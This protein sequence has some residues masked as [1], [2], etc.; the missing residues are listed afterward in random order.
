MKFATLLFVCAAV[1]MAE[2]LSTE[3]FSSSL[4]TW[5]IDAF[6]DENVGLTIAT[7]AWAAGRETV[8]SVSVLNKKLPLGVF[9]FGSSRRH[10]AGHLQWDA[11]EGVVYHPGALESLCSYP[12]DAYTSGRQNIGHAANSSLVQQCGVAIEHQGTGPEFQCNYTAEDYAAKFYNYPLLQNL[13]FGKIWDIMRSTCHFTDTSTMLKAQQALLQKCL[14]PPPDMRPF[15]DR[16]WNLRLQR[17]P[18]LWNEVIVSP[19]AA[20][21]VAG[22]F[23]AHA[24]PFREPQQGDSRACDAALNLQRAGGKLSVFEFANFP[25]TF[26]FTFE[27]LKDWG[28]TLHA[29]GYNVSDHFRLVESFEFLRVLE[30]DICLDAHNGT[31]I[32][33]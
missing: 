24:G 8:S 12:T 20:D 21:A 17:G 5:F 9:L 11:A 22:V 18:T 1:A 16:R 26:Q 32:V 2:S 31:T 27:S 29:G 30:S 7:G 25:L 10:D 13:E 28:R 15:Q 33:A 23:W 6:N 19:Y 3:V 14:T 4:P